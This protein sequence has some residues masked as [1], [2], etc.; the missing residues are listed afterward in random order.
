MALRHAV[1]NATRLPI[2]VWPAVRY[3]SVNEGEIEME[4]EFC[5]CCGEE[6]EATEFDVCAVCADHPEWEYEDADTI[7]FFENRFDMETEAEYKLRK[8]NRW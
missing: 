5:A 1:V 2:D 3:H 4:A 7:D 6:L 8:E